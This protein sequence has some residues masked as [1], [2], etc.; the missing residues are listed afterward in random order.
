MGI[1]GVNA[2]ATPNV[3]NR[4]SPRGTHGILMRATV[5]EIRSRA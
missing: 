2:A 4:L 3:T 1:P 5:T